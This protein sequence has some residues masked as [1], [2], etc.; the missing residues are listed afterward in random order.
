MIRGLLVQSSAGMLGLSATCIPYV[1]QLMALSRGKNSLMEML[2]AAMALVRYLVGVLWGNGALSPPDGI[3]KIIFSPVLPINE[4]LLFTVFEQV[5]KGGWAE[6]VESPA[7]CF[8]TLAAGHT[9]ALTQ[10]PSS[11][12]LFQLNCRY[13]VIVCS[14]LC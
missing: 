6:I 5:R 1:L 8:G 2:S 13:P 9:A 12:A 14:I 4:L 7:H 10:A 11:I 3:A